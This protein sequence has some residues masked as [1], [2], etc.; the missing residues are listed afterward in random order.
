[1]VGRNRKEIPYNLKRLAKRHVFRTTREAQK[2]FD[3]HG[4]HLSLGWLSI[5]KTE[6]KPS[7]EEQKSAEFREEDS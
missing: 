1:M 3:E 7:R 2:W 4:L 5:N 6:W